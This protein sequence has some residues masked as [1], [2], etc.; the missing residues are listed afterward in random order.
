MSPLR[1]VNFMR[2]AWVKALRSGFYH[3][4]R[5]NMRTTK[6]YPQARPDSKHPEGHCVLGV[7]CE[8]FF[9]FNPGWGWRWGSGPGYSHAQLVSPCDDLPPPAI[10]DAFG[11]P[12][13][14]AFDVA[15]MNDRGYTFARLADH[16]EAVWAREDDPITTSP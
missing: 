13:G 15:K 4:G 7:M 9:A 10:L 2:A 16:L 14:F 5:E 1:D 6:E 3:Q 11:I 8:V 12:S